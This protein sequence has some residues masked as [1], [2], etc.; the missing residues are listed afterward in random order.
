MNTERGHRAKS[1]LVMI[2]GALS[3]LAAAGCAGPATSPSPSTTVAPSIMPSRL[4]AAGGPCSAR[5]PGCGS[6]QG[7]VKSLA[8]FTWSAAPAPPLSSRLGQ[9]SAWTG[10]EFLIWGG[11]EQ[12]PELTLAGD[13][14]AYNPVT[15]VWTRIP[16]SPLSPRQTPFA[17]WTG[18]TALFW[19]GADAKGSLFTDGA[20]Y[21]PASRTWAMLPAAPLRP[22]AQH[23]QA[24]VWTGTQ[25]VVIQPGGGAA[26]APATR[27]WTAVP[28]LPQ[29]T[30]CQ[31]FA[32]GAE[33]TGSQVITWVAGRPPTADGTTPAG[34]CF[35]AYSW[36][37]GARAWAAVPGKPGYASFPYGTAAPVGGRLLFLGGSDCPPGASCPAQDFFDGT[38]FDPASGMWTPLPETFSG[39]RGPAVWT[40]SAMAVFATRAGAASGSPD[41][42]PKVPPGAVAAFD[43][44]GGTWTSL[45]RCPV[46][47]LANASLAWTG[48]QLIVVAMNGSNPQAEVLGAAPLKRGN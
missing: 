25:M 3:A 32:I 14:A 37:P 11:L 2:C 34:F 29:V 5:P 13:G 31:P 16:T 41:G 22:D 21:D 45:A 4:P 43:P 6:I 46:S 47:D 44:S 19:G 24:A 30:G 1:A 42:P 8:G 7:T 35:R 26:F 36:V 28:A 33:W 17:A 18:T 40:G 23:R 20:G 15:R 27:S 9:A 38:W 10:S 12:D 39:G 48:R